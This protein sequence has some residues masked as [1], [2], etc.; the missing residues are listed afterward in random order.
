MEMTNGSEPIM[1]IVLPF[2]VGNYAL[3]D[4]LQ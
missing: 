3:K 1:K 2:L 4:I